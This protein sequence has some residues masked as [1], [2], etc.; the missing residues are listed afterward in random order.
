MAQTLWRQHFG[1]NTLVPSRSSCNT[2]LDILNP[3]QCGAGTGVGGGARECKGGAVKKGQQPDQKGSTDLNIL[4][5]IQSIC[6]QPLSQIACML[7]D[8]G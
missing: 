1:A 3:I 6:K 5:L 7:P 2:G 8:N 4:D